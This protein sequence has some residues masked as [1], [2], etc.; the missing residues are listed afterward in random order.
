ME[1]GQGRVER[2]ASSVQAEQAER[3]RKARKQDLV[4]TLKDV[5]RRI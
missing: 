2:P 3:A 5:R 1:T 4:S